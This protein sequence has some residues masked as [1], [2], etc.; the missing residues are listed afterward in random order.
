ML[1]FITTNS[2][3]MHIDNIPEESNFHLEGCRPIEICDFPSKTYIQPMTVL[4]ISWIRCVKWGIINK[5]LHSTS[6]KG[7]K[8][9][10]L[11]CLVYTELHIKVGT[12]VVWRC[13]MNFR[14]ANRK[15]DTGSRAGAYTALHS[16]CVGGF[17]C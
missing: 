3:T 8:L 2:L 7:L 4:I 5:L 6:S 10:T 16:M 13:S 12:N 14:P 15:W 9:H 17:L 11:V 1:L